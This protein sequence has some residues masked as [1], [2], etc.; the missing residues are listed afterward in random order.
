MARSDPRG[1]HV[2]AD[3]APGG[4]DART[5]RE[6]GWIGRNRAALTRAR[7]IAA[8]AVMLAPPPLRIPL[9]A[10]CLAIDGVLL[11]EEARTGALPRQDAGMR[12]IGLVLESGTLLAA[13][14]FAPAV[15]ARNAS[16]IVA[17]R[18]LLGRMEA[19]AADR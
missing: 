13:T 9:A 18:R 5:V 3:E 10:G 1:P 11:A 2:L 12:A 16:Q 14:R 19:R 7:A 17:A 8:S 15:L 6:P 4:E